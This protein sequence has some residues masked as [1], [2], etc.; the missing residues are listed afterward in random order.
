MPRK[1]VS[2]GAAASA[3]QQV[4]RQAR[5]L[6]INLR[7]DIRLKES[8]LSKLREEEARQLT[9]PRGP[10]LIAFDAP[11]PLR[12]INDPRRASS[13]RSLLSIDSFR[14]MSLRRLIS[15][16]RAWRCTCWNADAAPRDTFL[17]GM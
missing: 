17:R 11:L 7:K 5:T 13:S 9:R 16:V 15:S 4:Q 8:I 10:L 6:L 14:R 12:P 1:K 3:F 2:R